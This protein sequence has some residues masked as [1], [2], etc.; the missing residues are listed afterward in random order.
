MNSDKGN[1]VLS[2]QAQDGMSLRVVGGG[3]TVMP[4]ITFKKQFAHLVELGIKDPGNPAGKRQSIRALRKRQFKVGDRLYLYTGMRT[5]GCRKLGEAVVKDVLP[6]E[7]SRG[8]G[9]LDGEKMN[10][11]VF[12]HIAVCD[13]FESAYE[14]LNWFEKEHGLPFTGQLIRW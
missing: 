2:K 8:W 3:D 12:H 13:G 11:E 4:A 14:M 7:F 5:K 6:I 1:V 9:T 10:A